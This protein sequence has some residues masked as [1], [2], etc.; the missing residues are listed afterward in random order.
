MYFILYINIAWHFIHVEHG[1]CRMCWDGRS[2]A[3]KDVTSAELVA[4][5]QPGSLL[6]W[7]TVT[8]WWVSVVTSVSTQQHLTPLIATCLTRN[9]LRRSLCQSK[10]LPMFHVH[11]NNFVYFKVSLGRVQKNKIANFRTLSKL[12][13][14]PPP[15]RPFETWLN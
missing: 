2:W 7:H 8:R 1:S 15:P 3:A 12:A 4:A 13:L 10:F 14:T 6:W 5:G 11:L 9:M